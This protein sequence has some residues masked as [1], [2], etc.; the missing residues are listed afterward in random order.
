[1]SN[2]GA[3]QDV[4]G[5]MKRVFREAMLAPQR[6]ERT[7]TFLLLGAGNGTCL[8]P[9]GVSAHTAQPPLS[10]RQDRVIYLPRR[11]QMGTHPFGL[12]WRDPERQFQEERGR[13]F[14]FLV[15][16]FFGGLL[17]FLAHEDEALPL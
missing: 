9:D 6:S 15:C 13:Q 17:V 1:V 5:L 12:A 16:L 3:I 11:F 4:G 7:R 10:L 14:V 2:P 8:L